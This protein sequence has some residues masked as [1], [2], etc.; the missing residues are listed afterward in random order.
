LNGLQRAQ[1]EHTCCMEKFQFDFTHSK[2][3]LRGAAP[4]APTIPDDRP[5]VSDLHQN[6]AL[7][8]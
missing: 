4:G 5:A 7:K 6:V 8:T 2:K 1:E 3:E